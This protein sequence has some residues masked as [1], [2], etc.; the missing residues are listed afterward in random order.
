MVYTYAE[1]IHELEHHYCRKHEFSEVEDE[2]EADSWGVLANPKAELLAS[3]SIVVGYY[4]L[5]EN[6]KRF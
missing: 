3:F 6:M 4:F 2:V 1:L 5:K